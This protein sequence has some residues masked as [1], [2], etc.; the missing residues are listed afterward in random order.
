MSWSST[1]T[2]KN[3]T[4]E[5][6]FKLY[7]ESK[8]IDMYARDGALMM[9]ENSTNRAD[10]SWS[11]GMHY[12]PGES[13]KSSVAR[14]VISAWLFFVLLLTASY[15][16][17]LSSFLTTTNLLPPI[18][19]LLS[20]KDSRQSIGYRRGSIVEEY[21]TVRF[22]IPKE[23]LVPIRMVPDFI[24]NLTEGAVVA[25]VDEFPYANSILSTLSSSTCDFGIAG[26]RLSQ[27]GFG[28]VSNLS[29][30]L[31]LSPS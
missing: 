25:I 31:S 19:N 5:G 7:K 16:A 20:L 28:F 21:L 8:D 26:S 1:S 14:G 30:S 17:G 18:P 29:L 2:P 24:K 10:D 3:M 9:L 27:E 15:T 12:L 22:R 13:L 6:N 11:L 4:K 23:R